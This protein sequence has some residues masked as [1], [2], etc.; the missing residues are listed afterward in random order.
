VNINA[1]PPAGRCFAI[2]VWFTMKPVW[3]PIT[4]W[5]SGPEAIADGLAADKAKL[6]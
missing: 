6:N 3:P 1:T 2:L 4:H 5:T